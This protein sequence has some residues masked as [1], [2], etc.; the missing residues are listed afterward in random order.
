MFARSS[1]SPL[2]ASLS[3]QEFQLVFHLQFEGAE[4][5]VNAIFRETRAALR[6]KDIEALCVTSTMLDV[7]KQRTACF[8]EPS[9]RWVLIAC[10]PL[11]RARLRE[12]NTV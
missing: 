5:M 4:S 1:G 6:G 3:L 7:V 11:V 9:E 2:L 8:V 12:R 10:N